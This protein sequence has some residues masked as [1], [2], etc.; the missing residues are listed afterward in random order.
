[1]AKFDSST[2]FKQAGE[3]NTNYPG[4][5]RWLDYDPYEDLYDNHSGLESFTVEHKKLSKRISRVLLCMLLISL[6][7]VT[8][9]ICTHI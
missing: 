3:F 9:Y 7:G 1:M 6:F 2:Q 5:S 8:V 4:P